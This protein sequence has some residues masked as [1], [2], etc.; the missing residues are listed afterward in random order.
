MRKLESFWSRTR[1]VTK[2]SDVAHMKS[3][4]SAADK[5]AVNWTIGSKPNANSRRGEFNNAQSRGSG[6][7]NWLAPTKPQPGR[8]RWDRVREIMTADAVSDEAC[9]KDGQR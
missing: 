7:L 5:P 9:L 2:K 1:R 3:I 8:E 6:T 4:W